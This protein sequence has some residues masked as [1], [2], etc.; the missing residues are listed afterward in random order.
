MWAADP[1]FTPGDSDSESGYCSESTKLSKEDC[2]R[3][4]TC[5]CRGAGLG[6]RRHCLASFTASG[7]PCVFMPTNVWHDGPTPPSASESGVCSNPSFTTKRECLEYGTCG[8]TKHVRRSE[9]L[10]DG[11][12][13]PPLEYR[14]A[15]RMQA[16]GDNEV[17]AMV[18]PPPNVPVLAF[19][20]LFVTREECED[21]SSRKGRIR[22]L[23][24]GRVARGGRCRAPAGGGAELG[25]DYSQWKSK[26]VC[27]V[28]RTRPSLSIGSRCVRRP[29]GPRFD[30]GQFMNATSC[31]VPESRVCSSV[32]FK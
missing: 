11:V 8:K 5:S 29:G 24:S 22:D 4:G 2:L 23:S 18:G 15:S 21:P 28:P 16:G 30:Y 17:A 3:F 6:V 32:S 19:E 13:L 25:Y 20:R 7:K 12:C 1:T 9:C 27:E 31:E 14:R 26:E 10:S